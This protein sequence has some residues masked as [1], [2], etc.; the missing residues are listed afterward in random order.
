VY[1]KVIIFV[2]NDQQGV[3]VSPHPHLICEDPIC[4]AACQ[5]TAGGMIAMLSEMQ[6]K[7]GKNH[8]SNHLRPGEKSDFCLCSLLQSNETAP[9][10]SQV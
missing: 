8:E 2:C 1:V 10:C 4:I 7:H 3:K 6:K 5:R 9:D